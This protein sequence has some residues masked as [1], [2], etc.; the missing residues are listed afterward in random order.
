MAGPAVC[1][2]A[3]GPTAGAR[4][5]PGG[6]GR[7][8]QGA[9]APGSLVALHCFSLP[10]LEETA[11]PARGGR[12]DTDMWQVGGEGAQAV[13]TPGCPPRPLPGALLGV[14]GHL[15]LCGRC[16]GSIG[17][18][19]GGVICVQLPVGG[20][21]C[22]RGGVGGAAGESG[23]PCPTPPIVGVLGPAPHLVFA[24]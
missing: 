19:G 1:V 3:V 17:V 4:L 11:A 16:D 24:V 6:C 5:A 23:G 8:V 10:S 20:V 13:P 18:P 15:H 14:I 9:R 21:Q 2:L 12:G 22:L 7:R